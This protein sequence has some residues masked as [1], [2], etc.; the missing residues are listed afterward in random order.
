MASR[1]ANE[2]RSLHVIEA[3]SAKIT[4]IISKRV[5]RVV[6]NTYIHVPIISGCKCTWWQKTTNRHAGHTGQPQYITII[7][8]L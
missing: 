2:R 6:V 5:F 8:T 7:N 4:I 3:F 1:Q